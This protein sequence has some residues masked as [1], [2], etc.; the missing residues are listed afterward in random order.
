MR[1]IKIPLKEK[2]WIKMKQLLEILIKVKLMFTSYAELLNGLIM[3]KVIRGFRSPQKKKLAQ[4]FRITFMQC[5]AE[6]YFFISLP[7]PH[8]SA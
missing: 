1:Q 4:T 2:C 8:N 5:Y 7:Y 6:R 3:K